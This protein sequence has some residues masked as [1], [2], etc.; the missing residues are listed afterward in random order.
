MSPEWSLWYQFF[1][2]NLTLYMF[3]QFD[4]TF[5]ARKFEQ[6]QVGLT[7]LIKSQISQISAYFFVILLSL[8]LHF[9]KRTK[10]LD[11]KLLQFLDAYISF[12]E[13]SGLDTSVK[14]S[15]QKSPKSPVSGIWPKCKT[16]TCWRTNSVWK[17]GVTR[18]I[19]MTESKVATKSS[20]NSQLAEFS[21]IA[22]KI[23]FRDVF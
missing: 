23:F 5:L 2:Q 1:T 16:E 3:L 18:F 22:L 13:P 6:S 14:S 8:H 12:K 11:Q 10:W 9:C 4:R 20:Q 21:Q 19:R 15:N 7:G 17:I